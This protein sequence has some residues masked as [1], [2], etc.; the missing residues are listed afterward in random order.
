TLTSGMK[1]ITKFDFSII[2][3]G[4]L[5]HRSIV[6]EYRAMEEVFDTMCKAF[7]AAI[8]RNRALVAGTRHGS[9]SSTGQEPLIAQTT[10]PPTA[11]RVPRRSVY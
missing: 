6:T 4:I 7:A 11:T 2:G 5:A 8:Q 3:T 9:Q 10:A 1:Q